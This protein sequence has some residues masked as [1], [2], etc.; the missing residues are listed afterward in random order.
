[1]HF[2][3]QIRPSEISGILT[4]PKLSLYL[5]AVS[6]EL[7]PPCFSNL[8]PSFQNSELFCVA[9]LLLLFCFSYRPFNSVMEKGH[10]P[11][12]LLVFLSDFS[13]TSKATSSY[14][15]LDKM[16]IHPE[17]DDA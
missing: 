12:S 11:H 1:M 6:P 3:S 14:Q 15:H 8:F 17:C 9:F 2:S 4:H 16:K 7:S 10:S 5:S 13:Q